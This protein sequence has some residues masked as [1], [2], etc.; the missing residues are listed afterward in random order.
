MTIRREGDRREG[1]IARGAKIDVPVPPP[2]REVVREIT[3]YPPYD[4][5]LIKGVGGDAFL[6]AQAIN[7]VPVL[8][9]AGVIWEPSP[10][11]SP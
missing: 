2:F 5:V 4:A 1:E 11:Q 7:E 6:Q 3:I 8:Q 9:K 10:K